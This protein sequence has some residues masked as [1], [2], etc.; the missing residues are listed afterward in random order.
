MITACHLG[1]QHEQALSSNANQ[2]GLSFLFT[3]PPSAI[4]LAASTL[5]AE[6]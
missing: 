5:F 3:L 2:E 4:A 1:V 6:S